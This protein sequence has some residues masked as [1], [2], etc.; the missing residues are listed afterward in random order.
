M[1]EAWKEGREALTGYRV[2][3]LGL[4]PARPQL[5]QR[6]NARARAMFAQGLMEET[7]G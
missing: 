5:Y 2:L 3:R 6:I 4:D 7:R 1:S